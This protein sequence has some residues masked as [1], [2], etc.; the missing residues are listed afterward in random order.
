ML[1]RPRR[2]AALLRRLFQPGCKRNCAPWVLW[3]KSQQWLRYATIPH[4]RICAGDACSGAAVLGSAIHTQ[5]QV[6]KIPV[7][8]RK[9]GSPDDMA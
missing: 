9:P 2:L 8:K 6:H 7:G 1:P 4:A 5:I 3:G